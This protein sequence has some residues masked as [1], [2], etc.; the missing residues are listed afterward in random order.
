[1]K[2]PHVGWNQLA[3]RAAAP[4]VDGIAGGSFVY[5]THSYRAPAGDAALATTDYAGEFAAIVQRG[6]VYGVQFHPEKSARA[7]LQLLRNF[8]AATPAEAAC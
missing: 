6:N 8:C 5:Y 1:M 2:V 4:L 7:G 3:L